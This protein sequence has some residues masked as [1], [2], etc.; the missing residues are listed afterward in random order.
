MRTLALAVVLSGLTWG[1][2]LAAPAA[3]AHGGAGGAQLP[4]DAEPVT[5]DGAKA[6]ERLASVPADPTTQALVAEP[7]KSSR[8]AL[9][10][11]HGAKLAGDEEG[12]SL[13]SRVALGWADAAVALVSAALSESRAAE[14][15]GKTQELKGK[16]ERAR[17]LLAET[18]ARKLQLLSSV[19]K[20]EAAAK[21]APASAPSGATAKKKGEEPAKKK[22]EEATKPQKKA[23]A[24]APPKE[25]AKA[26]PKAPAKEKGK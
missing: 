1:A 13:L 8:L 20:A 22:G 4:P 26:Q 24:P 17:S 25:P 9:G 7:L 15:E 5:A 21:A 12:A 14:A 19:S 18:E 11:A 6:K 10:R 2:V 23:A 16:I 3:R